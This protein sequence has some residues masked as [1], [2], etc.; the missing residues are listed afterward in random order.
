MYVYMQAVFIFGR[1]AQGMAPGARVPGACRRPKPGAHGPGRR[2]R[3]PS[4][5]WAPGLQPRP[6]ARQGP[7][8]GAKALVPSRAE[9]C[10]FLICWS[11]PVFGPVYEENCVT[12]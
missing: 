8:V 12:N 1:R 2:A 5:A 11:L 9:P 4:R 7:G 6:G 10:T 3:R